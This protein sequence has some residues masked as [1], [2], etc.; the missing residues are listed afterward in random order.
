MRTII[1]V[2]A[3][4]ELPVLRQQRDRNVIFRA[5][6]EGPFRHAGQVLPRNVALAWA[7][8]AGDAGLRIIR[9][10][11]R[12][13]VGAAGQFRRAGGVDELLVFGV[14]EGAIGI[15]GEAVAGDDLE[16]RLDPL[17]ADL[18]GIGEI[19]AHGAELAAIH[20]RLEILDVGA[21]GGEVEG[22]PAIQELGLEA[23]FIMIDRFRLHRAGVVIDGVVGVE[24]QAI[25][26]DA[27]RLEALRIGRI[28]QHVRRDLVVDVEVV[29]EVPGAVGRGTDLGLVNAA[30]LRRPLDGAGLRNRG[31]ADGLALRIGDDTLVETGLLVIVQAHAGLDGQGIRDLPAELPEQGGAVGLEPLRVAGGQAGQSGRNIGGVVRVGRG[32]KAPLGRI[33]A[34]LFGA[35]GVDPLL[36]AEQTDDEVDVLAFVII[37]EFLAILVLLRG[38]LRLGDDRQAGEVAVIFR[39]PVPEAPGGDRGQRAGADIPFDLGRHAAD[40][41]AGIEV[42]IEV[43]QPV[44]GVAAGHDIAL[45]SG[46]CIILA[47]ERTLGLA[48]AHEGGAAAFGIL[49]AIVARQG[50][51]E[52]LGRLEQQLAANAQIVLLVDPALAGHIV[53]RAAAA[54]RGDGDAGGDRVGQRAGNGGLRLLV[55]EIADRQFGA[56]LE[57]E[58]R[59]VGRDVDRARRGV[60][61]I[62]RALRTAQHFHLVDVEKVEG[63]GGDAAVID[64]VDIDADALFKAVAGEAERHA[65]AADVDRSVAGIGGIDL[66]RRRELLQLHDVEIAGRLDA[67]AL[68]HGNGQ[69]HFLRGFL[70]AAGGDDDHVAARAAGLLV[71]G[72]SGLGRFGRK[73]GRRDK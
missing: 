60:L 16:I 22:R 19:A 29:G 14:G 4:I 30:L 25:L 6:G 35:L 57:V 37:A 42:G 36:E 20:G 40:L 55:V 5:V 33:F 71:I 15:G 65:K 7:E 70:T 39:L 51:A 10:G 18:A 46:Q 11:A 28:G 17:R 49:L 13:L 45:R 47:I 69:G 62:E 68:H 24:R 50:E 23:D 58:G 73:G 44:I 63:R 34:L 2:D 72:G 54:G 52:I 56:P 1:A 32:G 26:V 12:G 8:C 43:R 64:I 67:V 3:Q 31:A 48:D 59:L 21:E 27:Q 61:A 9:G 38:V 41:V 53:E 66:Q